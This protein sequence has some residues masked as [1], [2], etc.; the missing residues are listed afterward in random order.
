MDG[1]KT[2]E[3]RFNKYLLEGDAF[4]IDSVLHLLVEVIKPVLQASYSGFLQFLIE[5]ENSSRATTG[6]VELRLSKRESEKENKSES[7]YYSEI[8]Q[9]LDFLKRAI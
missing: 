8:S 3:Q 2:L 4:A 7:S 5:M 6:I 1:G 9:H